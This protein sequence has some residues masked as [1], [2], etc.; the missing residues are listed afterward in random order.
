[1]KGFLS[2]WKESDGSWS[3]ARMASTATLI[4]AIWGFVHVILNTHAL[5]DG[6]ALVGLTTWAA[7]PYFVNKTATA[8]AR[9]DSAL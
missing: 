4:S 3:W 6:G 5:P 1:M 2:I 9:K 7:G 8:L